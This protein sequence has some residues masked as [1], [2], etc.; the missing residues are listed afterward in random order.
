VDLPTP[1]YLVGDN[2]FVPAR[3]VF[4]KLGRHVKWDANSRQLLVHSGPRPPDG[5]LKIGRA[6]VIPALRMEGIQGPGNIDVGLWTVSGQPLPLPAAPQMI[7]GVFYVP[8][9]AVALITGAQAAWD[10]QTLTVNLTVMPTGAPM[11]TNLGQILTDPPGWAGKLV[12]VRGEYT[13]WLADP[14]GP[15]TSS[16]PPVTRSDW[17]C[18]DAGGSIYCTGSGGGHLAP[19]ADLGRRIEVTGLV[20]LAPAGYPYL[21]VTGV[22]LLT[23]LDGL[24]RY[25][26][27]DRRSYR[28]GDIVKMQMLVANPGD[29]SLTLHFNSGKAYDFS[30]LSPEGDVVWAWSQGQVFT[31]ALVSRELKPGEKYTV[32]ADWTVPASLPP[33]LYSVRGELTADLQSYPQTVAL[34]GAERPE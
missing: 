6:E 2:A 10:P 27:T 13:G 7:G 14:N 9:R 32:S 12:R 25:L 5:V 20:V 23:G 19:L 16:G 26:T 31:M 30:V 33:G 24:T 8:V 11:T 28:P 34:T 21:Q 18:R 17:T 22:E 3:A 4:E 29:A 1:A 15:A